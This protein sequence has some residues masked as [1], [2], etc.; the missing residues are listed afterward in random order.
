MVTDVSISESQRL[1]QDTTSPAAPLLVV[2]SVP[3]IH[4]EKIGPG[5]VQERLGA[6][7]RLSAIPILLFITVGLLGLSGYYLFKIEQSDMIWHSIIWQ[8]KPFP[9]LSSTSSRPTSYFEGYKIEETRLG[10]MLKKRAIWIEDDVDFGL[11]RGVEFTYPVVISLFISVGL[12]SFHLL[13]VCSLRR[14]RRKF[15]LISFGYG[16]VGLLAF[17]LCLTTLYFS[18]VHKISCYL[19]NA[20][21]PPEPDATDPNRNNTINSFI[22][23]TLSCAFAYSIPNPYAKENF[24]FYPDTLIDG[25]MVEGVM[26]NKKEMIEL[27]ICPRQDD[28]LRALILLAITAALCWFVASYSQVVENRLLGPPVWLNRFKIKVHKGIRHWQ[29]RTQVPS[30]LEEKAKQSTSPSM[31]APDEEERERGQ[32]NFENPYSIMDGGIDHIMLADPLTSKPSKARFF[33][34]NIQ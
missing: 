19:E 1:P 10:R 11:A 7:S 22:N 6:F 9:S 27:G 3:S 17:T 8:N 13:L 12:L 21:I 20:R 28:L 14:F 16:F 23:M 25:F 4:Y 30:Y 18:F 2:S 34:T 26:Y 31:Y 24:M 33:I 15:Q 29:T 32:P 5:G